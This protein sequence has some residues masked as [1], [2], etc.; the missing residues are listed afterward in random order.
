MFGKLT[1]S[2]HPKPPNWVGSTIR[3]G[4]QNAGRPSTRSQSGNQCRS[5]N[6]NYQ[7]IRVHLLGINRAVGKKGI[8]YIGTI[9]PSY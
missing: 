4:W 1:A 6:S 2:Y 8:H 9:F 3:R 5:L 7:W